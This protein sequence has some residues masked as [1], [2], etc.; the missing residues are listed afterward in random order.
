MVG[1]LVD[2]ETQIDRQVTQVGAKV[3]GAAP[4][5]QVTQAA[6]IAEAEAATVQVTQVVAKVEARFVRPPTQ[7]DCVEFLVVDRYS[8]PLTWMPH[9][10][11]WAYSDRLNEPAA[12]EVTV[13]IDA[14]EAAHLVEGTATPTRAKSC[15]TS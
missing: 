4:T 13:P 15:G 7:A 12:G 6:A 9:V 11:N 14:P 8:T 1:L 2:G 5:V 10:T 3:E